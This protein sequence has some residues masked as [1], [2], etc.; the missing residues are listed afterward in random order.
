MNTPLPGHVVRLDTIDTDSQPWIGYVVDTHAGSVA[1][2]RPWRGRLESR[3]ASL[4]DIVDSYP[5]TAHDLEHAAIDVAGTISRAPQTQWLPIIRTA[6]R[7]DELA[8]LRRQQITDENRDRQRHI[9]DTF[10]ESLERRR[11]EWAKNKG[12]RVGA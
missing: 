6:A 8:R 7:L 5:T 1:V 4:D 9:V 10:N 12:R 11:T 3:M 2:V